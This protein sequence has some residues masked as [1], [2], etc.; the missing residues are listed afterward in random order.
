[1]NE[2]NLGYYQWGEG[3]E[4]WHLCALETLSV[5]K[6]KMPP[7]TQEIKHY[8]ASK[9]QYFFILEGELVIWMDHQEIHLKKHQGIT[10]LP[11]VTHEVR[12]DSQGEV[13]FLVISSPSDAMDRIDIS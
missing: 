12:N 8:H 1:M 11:T 3:C 7:G 10:V 5:I 6:E 4:G 9:T 13:T 2:S